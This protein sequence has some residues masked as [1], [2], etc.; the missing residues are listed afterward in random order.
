MKRILASL[1]A[2][3]TLGFSGA[4]TAAVTPALSCGTPT[5]LTFDNAHGPAKD[6]Y[7][8][9]G[10]TVQWNF[11]SPAEFTNMSVWSPDARV[12][13]TDPPTTIQTMDICSNA[14]WDVTFTE[15]DGSNPRVVTYPSSEY[16]F[17][18]YDG[19]CN[20]EQAWS[21]F[22]TLSST[23]AIDAPAE[24][25]WDQSYDL[26]MGDFGGCHQA[27]VPTIELM[28]YT[29]RYGNV[30]AP[31]A[32]ANF[33]LPDGKNIDAYWSFNPQGAQ[34]CTTAA[35]CLYIQTRLTTQLTSG[36]MHLRQIMQKLYGNGYTYLSG[37][38]Q[39][40]VMPYGAYL[41]DIQWGVEVVSGA[42]TVADSPITFHNTDFSVN[43]N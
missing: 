39:K 15:T 22:N 23:W 18:Q 25:D 10:S 13:A 32:M 8:A 31:N 2:V 19:T 29:K 20:Y 43:A 41:A 21:A 1:L 38:V 34:G 33:T 28:T 11:G 12:P 40:P 24:G 7:G 36:T 17:T 37:G 27:G 30:F 35:G 3:A 6:G 26:W 5:H 42:E 16:R 4:A 9:N 14:E